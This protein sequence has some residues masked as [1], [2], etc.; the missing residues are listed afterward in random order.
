M[1]DTDRISRLSVLNQRF[2]KSMDLLQE[3]MTNAILSFLTLETLFGL[4]I[5]LGSI[6]ADFLQAYSLIRYE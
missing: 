6:V 5:S 2:R 3:R 1:S 4:F